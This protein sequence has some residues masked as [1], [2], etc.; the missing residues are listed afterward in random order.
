MEEEGHPTSPCC[1]SFALLHTKPSFFLSFSA[2]SAWYTNNPRKNNDTERNKQK[3]PK[4]I[5]NC[6]NVSP[7]LHKKK[8]SVFAHTASQVLTRLGK[9]TR[10]LESSLGFCIK[11]IKRNEFDFSLHQSS[12]THWKQRNLW[13]GTSSLTFYVNRKPQSF[14]FGCNKVFAVKPTQTLKLFFEKL[15]E[16][17]SFLK[18]H[19]HHRHVP[20]SCPPSLMSLG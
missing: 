14:N 17:D 8:S 20:L 12:L 16:T 1:H 19:T 15:V 13:E 9:K 5:F 2:N 7:L 18:W 11:N 4:S 3:E 10:P 6:C